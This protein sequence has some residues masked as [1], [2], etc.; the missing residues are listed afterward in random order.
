MLVVYSK[1]G[2]LRW[3]T[4]M[5]D[6]GAVPS[7][8]YGKVSTWKRGTA[9]RV[10]GKPPCRRAL[11]CSQHPTH[12]HGFCPSVF[13]RLLEMRLDVLRREIVRVEE[14]RS[15]NQEKKIGKENG[16]GKGKGEWWRRRSGGF[17]GAKRKT[18]Y[19]INNPCLGCL[20]CGLSCC[21]EQST[22]AH[23]KAH[24]VIIMTL[25]VRLTDLSRGVW[26]IEKA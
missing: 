22:R 5:W 14:G 4:F 20:G 19:M 23:G 17:E 7:I 8:T 3:M 11:G 1:N 25:K 12:R 2:K 21:H 9:R 6:R 13:G 10:C 18:Q 15:K 16:K 26:L 24:N